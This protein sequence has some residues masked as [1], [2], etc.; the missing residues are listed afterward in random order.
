MTWA[1]EPYEVIN[2]EIFNTLWVLLLFDQDVEFYYINFQEDVW[3]K[4]NLAIGY[5]FLGPTEVYTWGDNSNFTLGHDSA[6]RRHH[7]E[8]IDSF[9]KASISIKQV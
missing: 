1:G 6:K 4:R 5:V 9:Q 2:D 3:F 8:M 7:H